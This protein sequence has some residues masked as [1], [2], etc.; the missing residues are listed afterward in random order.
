M[1]FCVLLG[2]SG[3]GAG[4]RS[5]HSLVKV[6]GVVTLDGTPVSGALVV[7][8]PVADGEPAA[9]GTTDADGSYNLTT[10]TDNDGVPPGQYKILVSKKSANNAMTAQESRDY[11]AKTG[12]APPIPEFHNEIPDQYSLYDTTELSTTIEETSSIQ[13]DLPLNN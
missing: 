12:E 8:S 1:F 13:I 9:R 6:S 4:N 11:F 7:Y 2:F 3:C 10:Y 5:G